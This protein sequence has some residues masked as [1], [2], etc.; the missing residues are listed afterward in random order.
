VVGLD[1]ASAVAAVEGWRSG[2]DPVTAIAAYNDEVA[3]A[4]LS[5]LRSTGLRA[6]QD[7]AVIGVDDIPAARLAAPALTTVWQA[8]DAQARYLADAVLAALDDTVEQPA[9]PDDVFHVVARD[10]T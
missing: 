3:L 5:G 1:V 8:I 7:V 6:P 10:S 4:V 2:A 9:Q